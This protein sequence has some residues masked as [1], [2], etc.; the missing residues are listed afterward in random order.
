MAREYS[1]VD[2]IGDQMQRELAV[3]IQREIKDPRVG[4]VTVNAVKVSRDLGYADVYVSLM[5]TEELSEQSPEVQA[6]LAVLNKAAGFLRGQ[7][8]R[9]M[10]LRVVPHLRFH[11]DALLGQS[12]RMDR[13]IREAVGDSPVVP[14]DDNDDPVSDNPERDA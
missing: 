14:R 3:L 1:R 7:V 2:R 6:S 11:F 12:R 10:K 13:L 8:G 5:S 4:M 9:A